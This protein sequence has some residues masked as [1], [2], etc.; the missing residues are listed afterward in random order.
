[1]AKVIVWS[2]VM[3][4]DGEGVMGGYEGVIVG[5]NGRGVIV[6]VY[7]EGCEGIMGGV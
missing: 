1:M 5:C 2:G 6:M 7:R 3:G 4:Y